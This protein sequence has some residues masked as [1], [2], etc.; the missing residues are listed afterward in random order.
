MKKFLLALLL[1]TQQLLSG[2]THMALIESAHPYLS[3]TDETQTYTL[4]GNPDYI[5][6]TFDA[7]T[8][9]EATYDFLH[10]MDGN[11][12]EITGSPFTGT[13]PVSTFV[14]PGDTVKVRL[15][16]D[17]S[18]EEWGYAV[19]SVTAYTTYT[20]IQTTSPLSV[21]F[22]GTAYS[23][24][25]TAI[26]GTEPYTWTIT[27]GALPNGL[28]IDSATG[29]ISGTVDDVVGT[30][31]FEV[32]VTDSLTETDTKQFTIEIQSTLAITSNSVIIN[33]TGLHTYVQ[34]EATGG[35]LPYT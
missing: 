20:T 33:Y 23:H 13:L 21:G 17:N 25:I 9:V 4:P 30:Y 18:V 34:L 3:D 27:S 2:D 12:N 22:T 1:A 10:I 5:K 7:R 24:L 28:S 14:I 19:T 26:N 31:T 16:S 6:V 11:N 35:V 8:S 29:E 15:V 32:T